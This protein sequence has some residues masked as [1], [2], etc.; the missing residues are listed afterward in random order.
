MVGKRPVD[1]GCT[2]PWCSVHNNPCKRTQ[3]KDSFE[4]KYWYMFTDKQHAIEFATQLDSLL[5]GQNTKLFK[6]LLYHPLQVSHNRRPAEKTSSANLAENTTHPLVLNLCFSK[7]IRLI[8]EIR[9]IGESGEDFIPPP[10]MFHM[11]FPIWSFEGTCLRM[12]T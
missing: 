4:K 5:G 12:F 3:K 9:P 1:N 10:S 8:Y 7:L 11:T 2:S 6:G